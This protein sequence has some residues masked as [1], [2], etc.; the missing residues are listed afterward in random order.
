MKSL[1]VLVLVL[2]LF[3]KAH[4]KLLMS[5]CELLW[6]G[7]LHRHCEAVRLS[8]GELP[9]VKPFVTGANAV[10]HH[11]LVKVYRKQFVLEFLAIGQSK[12]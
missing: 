6:F 9:S 3:E 11:A 7:T 4:L 2:L 8:V 1:S 12:S 10:L 5:V